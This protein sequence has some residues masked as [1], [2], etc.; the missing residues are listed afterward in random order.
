MA[1]EVTESAK[2]VIK[3]DLGTRVEFTAKGSVVG[4]IVEAFTWLPPARRQ[5]LLD[6][7]AKKQEELRAN[8]AERAAAATET[9]TA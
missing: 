1:R 6:R 5:K 9:A 7:L 4:G 3:N 2:F 8:E